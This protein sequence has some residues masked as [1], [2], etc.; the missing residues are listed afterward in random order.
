M[1][2]WNAEF[3]DLG[4][5]LFLEAIPFRET[6]NYC[7]KVLVSSVVYGYLYQDLSVR[8]VLDW[9]FLTDAKD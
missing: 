1:K 3:G 7:R 2:R 5:L 4:P 9:F 6:R 8:E